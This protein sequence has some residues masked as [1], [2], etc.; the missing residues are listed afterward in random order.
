VAILTALVVMDELTKV[1]R[2]LDAERQ[3][4]DQA[5]RTAAQ[6]DLKLQHILQESAK[7]LED[8]PPLQMEAETEE[9]DMEGRVRD[10]FDEGSR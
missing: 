6:L 9:L 1:R 2:T 7:P 3:R 8:E 5:A 10:L 4:F